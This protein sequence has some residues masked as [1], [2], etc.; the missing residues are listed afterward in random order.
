MTKIEKTARAEVLLTKLHGILAE[1]GETNWIR[2]VSA[3]LSELSSHS[4]IGFENAKSI[5]RTMVEGGRGFS[6]YFF[7]N[8]EDDVRMDSNKCIDEIRS[9]LWSIFDD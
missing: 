3:A 6:E 2:G 8:D 7:W 1:Q 5:Y 9:E 4:E